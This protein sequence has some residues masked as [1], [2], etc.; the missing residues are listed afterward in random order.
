MSRYAPEDPTTKDRADRIFTNL[1][2]MFLAPWL[3]MLF[4][5][6]THSFD[7]RVPAFGYW[8]TFFLSIAIGFVT[9]DGVTEADVFYRNRRRRLKGKQ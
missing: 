3:G 1:I 9:T 4:L 5:G 7:D 6:I 8:T 2:L